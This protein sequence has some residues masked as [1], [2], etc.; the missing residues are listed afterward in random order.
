MLG[1]L[2]SGVENGENF[3]GNRGVLRQ[4]TTTEEKGGPEEKK[5]R[6]ERGAPKTKRD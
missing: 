1:D 5:V 3:R 2:F 4:K 6:N